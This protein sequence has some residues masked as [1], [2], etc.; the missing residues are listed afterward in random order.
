MGQILYIGSPFT[1]KPNTIIGGVGS[2]ITTKSA[3]ATK[4]GIS[5]SIIQG[6]KVIGDDVYFKAISNYHIGTDSFNG[7]LLIEKY[8][9]LD[10][11]V[12]QVGLRAFQ[13]STIKNIF[14]PNAIFNDAAF[15][16]CENLINDEYFDTL[17]YNQSSILHS[18]LRGVKIPTININNAFLLPNDL[19]YNSQGVSVNFNGNSLG[20]NSLRGSQ[21]DNMNFPNVTTIG[22]TCFYMCKGP[23]ELSFPILVVLDNAGQTFRQLTRTKRLY[24][25]SLETITENAKNNLF[26]EMTSLEL[27]RMKKLKTFGLPT[28][29]NN[30][31][32]GIKSG[33]TI[34]VNIALATIN[35]GGA[36]ASLAWAKANRSAI[37]KFYDDSGNY[38]S[39]L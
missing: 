24:M 2:V 21:Y 26:R 9:D 10:G 22:S 15:A 20:Q 31:W 14:F 13:S 7:D 5:E 39:T 35:S 1:S 33:A 29:N 16:Y 3:L 4:L 11:L 18:S 38:V 12:S 34:E 25:D 32:L 6:F 37:V 28:S 27:I 36:E 17:N 30:V 19:L 8:I 23:D